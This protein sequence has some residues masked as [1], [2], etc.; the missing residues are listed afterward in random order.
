MSC[1]RP[2]SPMGHALR[3]CHANALVHWGDRFL[4]PPPYGLFKLPPGHSSDD[5]AP[6]RGHRW[7]CC[8]VGDWPP[9]AVD[10]KPRQVTADGRIGDCEQQLHGIAQQ[11]LAVQVGPAVGRE[12]IAQVQRQWRVGEPLSPGGLPGGQP[13]VAPAGF[14]CDLTQEQG[15]RLKCPVPG[16]PKPTSRLGSSLLSPCGR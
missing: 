13:L 11:D 3:R 5:D 12:Q 14:G 4:T 6:V 1:Y 15:R 8:T 9:D 10:S 16:L 7:V 2:A